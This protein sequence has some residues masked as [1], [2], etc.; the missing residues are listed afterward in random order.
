MKFEMCACTRG[1]A[2]VILVFG[3]FGARFPKSNCAGF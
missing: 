2:V 1:C 3:V